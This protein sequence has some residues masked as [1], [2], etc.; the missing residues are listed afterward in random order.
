MLIDFL[1]RLPHEYEHEVRQWLAKGNL[2]IQKAERVVR[3]RFKK[4]KA[5]RNTSSKALSAHSRSN[6]H[7]PT[8]N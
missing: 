8:P 7:A 4:L 5:S 6:S 3:T 1:D 2:T